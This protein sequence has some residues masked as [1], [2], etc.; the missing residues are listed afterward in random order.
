MRAGQLV[1]LDAGARHAM[2]CAD[3]SRTYAVGD[4]H[5]DVHAL[6]QLV[7]DAHDAAIAAAQPGAR[8]GDTHDAA[9]RVLTNGLRDLG[10]I[11]TGLEREAESE[12]LRRYYPHQT[13]HWLGLD[14][15]DVGD[16]VRDG[17][18]RVLEPGMAFTVEPGLY[19]SVSDEAA[20]PHLRGVGIRIEDDV[21]VTD[22]GVEVIT[23]GLQSSL[24]L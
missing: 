22:S 3:I 13:S 18:S 16:Y 7:R 5:A 14:V 15:H 10:L 8:M 4:V 12:A 17:A 23:A 2:Y 6:H 11:A 9:V 24:E 19:L 21:V 20:P 1:L